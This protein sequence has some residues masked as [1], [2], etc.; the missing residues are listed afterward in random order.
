MSFIRISDV[1]LSFP[2]YD[3]SNRSLKRR[4]ISAMARGRVTRDFTSRISTNGS[5]RVSIHALRRVNLFIEHGTRLGLIGLNGAG[6]STL[7]HV[8][9]GIYVPDRGAVAVEGKLGC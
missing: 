1:S 5:D 3:S 7:L 6:K 2:V 8:M 9:A 4:A